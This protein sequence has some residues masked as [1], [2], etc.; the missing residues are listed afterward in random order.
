MT[1]LTELKKVDNSHSSG[2]YFHILVCRYINFNEVLSIFLFFFFFFVSLKS[3]FKVYWYSFLFLHENIGCECSLGIHVPGI[4]WEIWKF[5]HEN[6]HR[7]WGLIKNASVGCYL[8]SIYKL[9]RKMKK[10]LS[11]SRIYCMHLD[12]HAWANRRPRWDASH[13][14]LH[15]LPLIQQFLDKTLGSELYLF[16][17]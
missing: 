2:A 16:K 14:N 17:F 15:C 4:S 11:G 7:L 1:T 12:R 6:S 13:Q 8:K 10:Y 3:I 5:L 9:W